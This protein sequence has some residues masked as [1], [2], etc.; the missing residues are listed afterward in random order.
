MIKGEKNNTE[1]LFNFSLTLLGNYVDV[2]I[3]GDAGFKH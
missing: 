2:V 1:D 3:Y